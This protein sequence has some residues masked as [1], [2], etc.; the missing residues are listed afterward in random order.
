M[1]IAIYLEQNLFGLDSK[2]TMGYKFSFTAQPGVSK[3]ARSL[4]NRFAE[5]ILKFEPIGGINEF[6]K[7]T[8]DNFVVSP[9]Q[10]VCDC[11]PTV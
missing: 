8:V 1:G 5:A 3:H 2:V 4:L 11:W 9:P 10:E 7:I 6:Y